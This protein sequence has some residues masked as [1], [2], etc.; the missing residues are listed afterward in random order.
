MTRSNQWLKDIGESPALI[1]KLELLAL[2]INVLANMGLFPQVMQ[3]L[4]GLMCLAVCV[5][6][7]L[8]LFVAALRGEAPEAEEPLVFSLRVRR[9]NAHGSTML[10]RK[11]VCHTRRTPERYPQRDS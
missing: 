11:R 3:V 9:G 1:M 4:G 8:T 2:V 6:A 5:V 7:G 10:R